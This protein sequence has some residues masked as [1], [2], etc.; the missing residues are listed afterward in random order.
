MKIT[1]AEDLD[2]RV[3]TDSQFPGLVSVYECE[4]QPPT[5]VDLS[6][7]Q[8]DVVIRGLLRLKETK[9]RDAGLT[10]RIESLLDYM[11]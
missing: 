8:V 2:V 4:S 1:Y 10:S 5:W 11:T 6:E 3:E 7:A 9:S